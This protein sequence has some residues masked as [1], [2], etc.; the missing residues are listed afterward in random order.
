MNVHRTTGLSRF[1]LDADLFDYE[2]ALDPAGD[3]AGPADPAAGAPDPGADPAA[4]VEPVEPAAAEPALTADQIAAFQ[5]SPEMQA[6]VDQRAADLA[7]SIVEGRQPQTTP[8]GGEPPVD[9]N[10]FL[11]PYGENFGANLAQFLG[12][13]FQTFQAQQE[14]TQQAT[15]AETELEQDIAARA[16]AAGLPDTASPLVRARAE[17]LYATLAPRFGHERGS[18]MALNQA[19]RE[20]AALTGTATTAGGQAEI[21]RLHAVGQA[22]GAVHG[23]G[24]A[25]VNVPPPAASP[26][27]AFNRHFGLTNNAN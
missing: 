27:E 15:A 21:D 22:A 6:W 4:A 1:G 23:N 11:D 2:P 26:R 19:V 18:D 5:N 9:L 10:E 3:P 13:Q 24:A 12:Q 17:Q 14:Q 16:T 25:A 20:L 7:A 8:Q